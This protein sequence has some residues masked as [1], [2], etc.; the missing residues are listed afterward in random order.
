M[1]KNISIKDTPT[2]PDAGSTLVVPEDRRSKF[3]LR[4]AKKDAKKFRIRTLKT[5]SAD[6]ALTEDLVNPYFPTGA[7]RA[8]ARRELRAMRE[9][10]LIQRLRRTAPNGTSDRELWV[11]V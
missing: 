5:L 9:E 10:G 6:Q 4:L 8:Q 7:T 3:P 11:K 1:T 2:I